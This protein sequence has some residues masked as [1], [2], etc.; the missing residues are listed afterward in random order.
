MPVRV[1]VT[2]GPQ[3]TFGTIAILDARTRRPLE[4]SP[5]PAAL[6]IAPGE[7]A[8]ADNVVRAEARL[9]D[10]WRDQGYPFAKVVSK[11]VVADHKTQKLNVTLSVD[12]GPR[13][14]FGTFTVS[15]ADFLTPGFIED[16][17]MIPPGT[18]Y[19]PERLNRLRR[20]LLEYQAIASVRI[21]EGERLDAQGRLPVF[22][23]VAP[24]EP[25]YVG[26][27]ATYSNTEGSAAN[28]YWGHRNL[29]GGAE[30]LRIDGQV[31]WFGTQPEAV[32]SADPFG[33][34]LA[35]S[36]TKPGIITAQEDLVAQ[37]AVLR[38]VTNAYVREGATFLAGVR[39][40]VD[41][42]LSV[43]LGADLETG[44]VEDANGKGP[45]DVIGVPADLKW[46]T[47]DSPLDP[48]SGFRLSAT[49]EPFAK[50]GAA[51]AGPVLAQG[52]FST[53]YGLDEERRYILAGRVGAGS[54][55]GV[56]D[57]Y[58]VPAQRRFYVGGGGSVRGYD[59]QSISPRNA[60]GDIVGGL[61]YVE[62][63]AE[64]RIKVTETIGVVPFF[65]MGA[66]YATDTP[67][68]S[69]LKYSAGIGL[70]YYTAV[71]PLRLDVAFPLNPEPDDA[72][73]GIYVSLGQAF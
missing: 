38:E 21:R 40:N 68:F 44:T 14:T 19:S 12:T 10:H 4:G 62:A 24:R 58:D 63:S 5:S 65:D 66:A 64:L 59:Y 9:V 33:Y 54:I 17:I 57:L 16:R 23:E 25:R 71:G 7:P 43:Q 22:I 34:K 18:P 37:A 55:F 72:G 3:F 1:E 70:R 73:Y 46:D 36:F 61:S 35:A 2:T 69:G 53:Y 30:T 31:S 48:A 47:T 29:W 41:D 13:A 6:W 49:L 56:S 8:L 50:L 39:H 60:D 45:A 28:V 32:P 11:D 42:Q 20:R 52:T 26:F 51:D 67:D 15:G 27:S